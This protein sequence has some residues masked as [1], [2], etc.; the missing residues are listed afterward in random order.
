M[1]TGVKRLPAAT[2]QPRLVSPLRAALVLAVAG[3]AVWAL[4]TQV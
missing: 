2:R 1:I 3:A 4:A